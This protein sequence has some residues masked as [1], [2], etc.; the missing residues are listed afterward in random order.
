MTL[1]S[2]DDSCSE[3]Y[4]SLLTG[5]VVVAAKDAAVQ[6]C[7]GTRGNIEEEQETIGP[8]ARGSEEKTWEL[9]GED[10]AV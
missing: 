8:R 6:R 1:D 5:R 7:E 3:D 2:L 9:N 4:H 10:V